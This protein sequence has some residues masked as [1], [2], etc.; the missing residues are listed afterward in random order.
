MRLWLSELRKPPQ[1]E[2]GGRGETGSLCWG[3]G[4]ARLW[5][6]HASPLPVLTACA[7]LPVNPALATF[8]RPLTGL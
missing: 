6:P 5:P 3:A 2:P 4:G 7:A 8:R 1:R